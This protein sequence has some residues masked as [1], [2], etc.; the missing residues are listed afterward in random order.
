MMD[1]L[2]KVR[3]SPNKSL[4]GKEG[5]TEWQEWVESVCVYGGVGAGP[6]QFGLINIHLFS[7]IS[8]QLAFLLN[9]LSQAAVL[10]LSL[11]SPQHS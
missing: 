9:A 4:S 1:S 3:I 6:H 10:D 7:E 11:N 8:C 5:V 2:M